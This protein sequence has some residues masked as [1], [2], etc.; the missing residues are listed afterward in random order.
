MG[1]Q[2]ATEIGGRLELFVEDGLIERIGGGASLRVN[3]PVMREITIQ[4]NKPWEGNMCGGY[5]TYFWDEARGVFRMYY[6]AWHLVITPKEGGGKP[7]KTERPIKIGY[8]ESKDGVTWERVMLGMYEVDGSRENNVT[9]MGFDDDHKGIHGFAPMIDRNP[10]CRPDERYKALGACMNWPGAKLYALKSAD[11]LKWELM[12][13]EP[14]MTKEKFDSQNLAFWDAQRGEYRAYVRG[15]ENNVRTIRTC[16]SKDFLNWTE[17]EGLEYP[18]APLEQLYTNQVMPYERA[19]HI[20]IGFPIRYVERKWSAA[21]ETLPE[22]EHRRLRASFSERYGAAVTDVQFMA[23]RDGKTFKRHGETFIRPGLRPQ[24]MWAYGDCYQ[25]WGLLETASDVKGAPSE[26]SMFTV[27]GY[28]RGEGNYF[29]RHTI[30]MDGFVSVHAGREG[31]ELVTKPVVFKGDRLVL[32]IATSA[33]GGCKVE[34]LDAEGAAIPGFTEGDCVEVLGDSLE[35]GVSWAGPRSGSVGKLAGR[36]V[37]LRFVVKDA[38]LYS[39][40]FVAEGSGRG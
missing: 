20:L 37:R 32:N 12:R 21:V 25:G 15:I 1:T 31:G 23:S 39:Y 40:R 30:R 11:G 33:A 17:S 19:P 10:D 14:V 27:E 24:G 29:R 18:G 6:Q 38:D 7:T 36:A 16:V 34:V 28:W 5:K 35:L 4:T 26:L 3:S 2:G 22:L 8:L 9:F 13:R